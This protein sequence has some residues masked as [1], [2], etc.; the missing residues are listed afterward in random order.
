[1]K[2]IVGVGQRRGEKPAEPCQLR[3]DHKQP[4]EPSQRGLISERGRGEAEEI[5]RGRILIRFESKRKGR[6]NEFPGLL[7]HSSSFDQ[8]R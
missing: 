1:M 2:R 3:G 4:T 6:G 8:P 7:T 5:A